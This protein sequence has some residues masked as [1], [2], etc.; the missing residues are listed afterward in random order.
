MP[1]GLPG[2]VYSVQSRMARDEGRA[3]GE[4]PALAGDGGGVIRGGSD[5]SGNARARAGEDDQLEVAGQI[6]RPT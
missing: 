6:Y 5:R 2:G 3:G 4:I 1:A